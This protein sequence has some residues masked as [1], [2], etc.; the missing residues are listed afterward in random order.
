MNGAE[1]VETPQWSFASLFGYEEHPLFIANSEV[2][3]HT[4]IIMAI[5]ALFLACVNF[6]LHHTKLG[7]YILIQVVSFFVDLTKQSL[8]V[9]VYGHCVFAA[10]LFIFIGLCN[11]APLIPW[12]EEPT[13]DLNTALAL[14]II[15]F[16][17]VQSVAIQSRGIIPYIKD[18]FQPIFVMLPLN[19]IGKLSS[20]VSISFR[21]F[22]NIFGGAIITKLYFSAISGSIILESLGLLTGTNFLITAFFTLFEGLLQAFVFAML[23]LTYLSISNQEGGGH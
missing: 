11:I 1:L 6:I 14:G 10:A 3:I 7:R 22:G 5:L 9:F 23:T 13:R 2:I 21:L 15:S 8:G 4:W 17:Y 18:F 12:L 16:I 19:V 20:I